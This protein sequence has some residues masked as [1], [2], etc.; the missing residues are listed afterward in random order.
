L[1]KRT[2][3]ITKWIDASFYGDD[4]YTK[5][6]I[7]QFKPIITYTVGFI[8]HK[9]EN[10]TIVACQYLEGHDKYGKISVIPT[11]LIIND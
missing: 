9:D 8:L 1:N 11:S 10:V 6:Q 5:E 3:K 2:A 4:Y 7:K